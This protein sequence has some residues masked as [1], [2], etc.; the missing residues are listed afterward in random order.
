MRAVK[1][2]NLCWQLRRSESFGNRGDYV[3]DF[4][5]RSFVILEEGVTLLKDTRR[6]PGTR[7]REDDKAN[8]PEPWIQEYFPIW[9]RHPGQVKGQRGYSLDRPVYPL[10]GVVSRD[11]EYLA[12]FAWPETRSLGQVWHDCLHPRPAIGES[13]DPASNH[14]VSHGRLYFLPN[15]EQQLLEAFQRDFPEWRPPISRR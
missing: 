7:D 5:A 8:L 3:T 13:Y 4:V 11:G 1:S 2:L 15:S 14:T 10:I 6:V 9:R 12:A